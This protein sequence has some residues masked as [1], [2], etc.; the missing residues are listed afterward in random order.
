MELLLIPTDAIVD[1]RNPKQPPA[2]YKTLQIMEWTTNL[3]WWTQ[4][5]W[6]INS[7]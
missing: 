6:T 5:F 2:M 7:R 4:D 3:I 1:G